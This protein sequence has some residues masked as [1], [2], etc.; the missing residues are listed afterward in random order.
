MEYLFLT[1]KILGIVFALFVGLVVWCLCANSSK[2]SKEDEAWLK[3]HQT[4]DLSDLESQT[5]EK[6][7]NNFLTLFEINKNENVTV[8]ECLDNYY[9]Y[10]GRVL[11]NDGKVLGVSI[12]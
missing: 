12:R 4:S 5:V 3:Q 11:L 6:L 2:C 8:G 9:E 7:K 10:D 1:L